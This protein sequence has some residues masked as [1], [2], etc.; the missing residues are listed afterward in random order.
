MP[1]ANIQNEPDEMTQRAFDFSHQQDHADIIDAIFARTGVNL[2][3]RA[4]FPNIGLNASWKQLHQD[5]HAAMNLLLGIPG[6]NLQGEIDASWYNQNYQEH[7]NA[8]QV[9]GI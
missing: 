2:P 6:Q 7:L 4:I 9:L 5:M 3:I 1:L 8:H